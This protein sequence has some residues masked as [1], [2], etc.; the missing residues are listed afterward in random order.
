[1][2]HKAANKNEQGIVYF[3][4]NATKKAFIEHKHGACLG[5]A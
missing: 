4:A 2:G 1:M 5:L 3:F